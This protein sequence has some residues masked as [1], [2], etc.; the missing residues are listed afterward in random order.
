M[1]RRDDR[2]KCVALV[3]GMNF[4]VPTSG[5]GKPFLAMSGTASEYLSVNQGLLNQ[6]QTNATFIQIQGADHRTFWDEA[7]GPKLPTGRPRA[8]AMDAAVVWFFA[9]Y[10][11]GETPPFPTNPAI[12]NVQRK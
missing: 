8:V 4:Q 7:W 11:K 2:L 9:T 3:D 6:A 5:I 1:C 10:L 12:V